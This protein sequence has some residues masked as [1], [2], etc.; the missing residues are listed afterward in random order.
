M[1]KKRNHYFPNKSDYWDA[2]NKC[3][4]DFVN[5]RNKPPISPEF[6]TSLETESHYAIFELRLREK[7]LTREHIEKLDND[8]F[9][10]T[11]H[12][13]VIVRKIKPDG[14][15]EYV[16]KRPQHI[17]M[18]P[19][20]SVD[21]AIEFFFNFR[22]RVKFVL[23]VEKTASQASLVKIFIPL[24]RK[25]F[26]DSLG[27]ELKTYSPSWC[28]DKNARTWQLK[29]KQHPLYS[30]PHSEF[31]DTPIEKLIEMVLHNNGVQFKKQTEFYFQQM[32]F[33]VPDFLLENEKIAIYCD[34]TEFHKDTQKI[35]KDK[36]QDRKL[37]IKGYMVLR[38]SGSEIISDIKQCEE[39]ILAAIK[40]RKSGT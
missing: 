12:R 37:Q 3:G 39:D 34:G 24:L 18:S 29:T 10:L 27:R 32:K 30:S 38:F 22:D 16:Y 9:A 6:Q 25:W 36:T 1:I 2:V 20:S 17:T 11:G 33:T 26:T 19:D 21:G 23:K 35:I 40:Q 13:V 14:L 8:F 7:Y 5:S 15:A 31:K 4:E 28:L